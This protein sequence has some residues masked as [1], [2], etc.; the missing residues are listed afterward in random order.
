MADQKGGINTRA[1]SA[2]ELKIKEFGNVVTPIFQNATFIYPNY[3]SGAISD[4]STGKPYIYTRWGNP[5]V[6]S[7]EQKYAAI[8]DSKF[9]ISF[10]SGMSA[11]SCLAM[12]I[13]K[14]G[15][16]LLS[17]SELYGQTYSYFLNKLRE[18]GIE[19]TFM[20]TN[21]LNEGSFKASEYDMIYAESITNPTDMVTDIGLIGELCN[22]TET[23]L[24][25]DATFA[26]PVNQNPLELGANYVVHSGT[27]YLSGHSDAICGFLGTDE[28]PSAIYDMRK[29]LG[30][31]LDPTQAY[32][33]AR[34]MKTIGLRVGRQNENA[35]KISKFLMENDKVESV[36][37]PGLES[38][39]YHKIA[40]KNLR[41][42][43]GMLSFEIKGG[44]DQARKFLGKLK[45][46][47]PAPS[48]G[49]VESLATLPIDT[50]HSS[51]SKAQREKIGIK[52][53]LVRF[54]CGIEDA[55]DLIEDMKNALDFL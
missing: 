50:S 10:S 7:L 3:E 5:T 22:G 34:G 28:D 23:K 37:Y 9:G 8:E 43:G 14:R 11:I 30:P 46:I 35:M 32:S 47:S 41:G 45:Y 17:A 36:F 27:K 29:N 44:V 4:P 51:M 49:G 55:E 33:I 1:V 53:G 48:L 19:V 40:K 31:V 24:A 15:M 20:D 38:S 2:G 25:I 39:P 42:Y 12:S 6:N 16:K 18:N 21:D 54:S 13:L 52:D 26:S